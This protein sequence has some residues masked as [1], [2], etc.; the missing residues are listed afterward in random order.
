MFVQLLQNYSFHPALIWKVALTSSVVL[1]IIPFDS[2]H[3]MIP[4]ILTDT[5]SAEPENYKRSRLSVSFHWLQVWLTSCPASSSV[6]LLSSL[7]GQ[8]QCSV[9]QVGVYE[10]ITQQECIVQSLLKR[11]PSLAYAGIWI[12][13]QKSSV[14][15]FQTSITLSYSIRYV[16]VT[17]EKKDGKICHLN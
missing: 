4:F 2:C 11:S 6:C 8:R 14:Q 12:I 13:K 15:L 7:C 1:W 3:F 10:W 16:P 17:V 9:C 5:V